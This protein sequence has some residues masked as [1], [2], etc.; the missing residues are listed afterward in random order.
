MV[1]GTVADNHVFLVKSERPTTMMISQYMGADEDLNPDDREFMKKGTD[2]AKRI[3]KM[4]THKLETLTPPGLN[5]MKQVELFTKWRKFVPT[6]LQDEVCPEP[7]TEIMKN[8]RKLKQDK[9]K[10]TAKAR[11]ELNKREKK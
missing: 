4:I 1:S 10:E 5:P 8:V 2:S 7:A 9:R 3:H 6:H 11:I